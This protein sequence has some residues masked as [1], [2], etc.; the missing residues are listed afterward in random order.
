[1][2]PFKQEHQFKRKRHATIFPVGYFGGAL[3]IGQ[4]QAGV[5]HSALGHFPTTGSDDGS[6]RC[7]LR[8]LLRGVNILT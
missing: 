3:I 4:V 5:T 8:L 2:H 1:L 7:F 6:A